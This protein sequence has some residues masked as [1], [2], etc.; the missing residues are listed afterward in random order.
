V[1][2]WLKGLLQKLGLLQYYYEL[3]PQRPIYIPSWWAYLKI[4]RWVVY[5]R[6]R[7]RM[8]YFLVRRGYQQMSLDHDHLVHVVQRNLISSHFA[9]PFS[10]RR[11]EHLIY[12][13]HSITSVNKE[14]RLLSIGPRNEGDLLLLQAHGFRHVEGIDLFTYSPLIQLMDMHRTTYADN[15][16]D[17][18]SSGWAVRYSYDIQKCAREMIRICKN[19]AHIAIA[20]SMNPNEQDT[21]AALAT[22]LRGG[23][24]ELLGYFQPHVGYV[25]WRMEDMNTDETNVPGFTH[26]VVFRVKKP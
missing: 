13:F 20:F 8:I 4:S 3:Y 26:S 25:Y 14:G 11:T 19:G 16:F 7:I 18:I 15:T 22:P 17:L 24:D 21:L 23:I 1:K 9:M 12:L 5:L 2:K 6:F 10:R